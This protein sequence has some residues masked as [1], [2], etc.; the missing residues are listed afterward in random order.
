MC[1]K[2]FERDLCSVFNCS[3]SGKSIKVKG[4]DT[5]VNLAVSLAENF[6]KVH[7]DFKCGDFWRRVGLRYCLA[8]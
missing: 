5:E 4:S 2:L 8:A 6:Y 1:L 3:D 7:Q